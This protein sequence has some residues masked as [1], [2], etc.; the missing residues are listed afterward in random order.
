MFIKP[1]LQLKIP[2]IFTGNKTFFL[3]HLN[4]QFRSLFFSSTHALTSAPKITVPVQQKNTRGRQPHSPLQLSL[5]RIIDSSGEYGPWILPGPLELGAKSGARAADC[6]LRR[7]C[8]GKILIIILIM[9]SIRKYVYVY[10]CAVW[11]IF[12][13]KNR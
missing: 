4:H 12:S 1:P 3:Q 2:P 13:V 5:R 7:H 9:L 11:L 10:C 8:H 6:K